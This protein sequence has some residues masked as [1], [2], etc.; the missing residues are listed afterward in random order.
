MKKLLAGFILVAA[1]TLVVGLVGWNGVKSVSRNL[2]EVSTVRLPALTALKSFS[3]EGESLRVAQ[4]TLLIPGLGQSDRARQYANE[5]QARKA[6]DESWKAYEALPKTAEEKATQGAL[7]KAWEGWRRGNNEIVS[8]SKN[9]DALGIQDIPDLRYKI[10]LFRGDH[11]KLLNSVDDLMLINEAFE[12]GESA[13][14]CNFG[15]WLAAE[16]KNIHNAA[17][18]D[19]LARIIPEHKKFHAG[20]KDIKELVQKGRKDEALRLYHGAMEAVDKTFEYFDILRGEVAKAEDVH[21]RMRQEAMVNVLEKQRATLSV[22][23]KMLNGNEEA[24]KLSVAQANA[25]ASEVSLATLLGMAAG[26]LFALAVGFGLAKL[27]TKPIRLGV[28]FADGMAQGDFSQNLDIDQKDEVGVLAK[29]LNGMVG[30][31]RTIVAEVQTASEQVASGSEELSSTSQAMSQGATEQAASVEEI[32]SSMEQMSS[33]IKQTA[34]NAQRTQSIAVKAAKDAATGGESVAQ[35]A[36]A[37]KRIAEKIS[38]VEDIARQTNLLAL[39]AAIEAARAG[40]HGKGFAVVAAEVRK[41]A[42]RS[43]VAASEISELSSQSVRVAEQAGQ[44]L[45]A[46]VPDI[47]KTADL[48]QEISAASAE[49]NAGAQQINKAVQQLDQVVQQNAAA[50]EQMS[51]TAEELSAQAEQLTSSMSFFHVDN[52]P[53][54]LPAPGAQRKKAG[55]AALKKVHAPGNDGFERF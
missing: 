39:N 34:E 26:V 18:Q 49:Q 51:S 20:V 15:K 1:I 54:A 3:E 19:A 25:T 23:G 10:E 47:Q 43:G 33:N 17:I 40:E 2:Q 36:A 31:L 12:G 8:L 55:S 42:E 9:L 11:Y 46:L 37:M 41:L 7:E 45:A 6:M 22:L 16:S 44:M 27:I 35:T 13:D 29:A 21:Q 52:A 53:R 50:C 24:A 48:I 14:G 28:S 4:R 38:I 5:E 30:R 32:S